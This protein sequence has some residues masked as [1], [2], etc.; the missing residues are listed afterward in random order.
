[1]AGGEA[2]LATTGEQINGE[3][4]PF[5]LFKQIF[6]IFFFFLEGSGWVFLRLAG[7]GAVA[8]LRAGGRSAAAV[9][10][11][12]PRAGGRPGLP[13]AHGGKAATQQILSG[14]RKRARRKR[15]K[16]R[17]VQVCVA[18]LPRGVS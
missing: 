11:G 16:A 13:R 9:W 2:G 18:G 3:K 10:R 6:L 7:R 5:P 8:M 12:C 15:R 17:S 14:T 4:S 1:M